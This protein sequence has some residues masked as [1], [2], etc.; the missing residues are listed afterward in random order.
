MNYYMWHGGT[1]FGRW[2]GGPF[3]ITSYDYD[4]MLDEYGLPNQPKYSHLRYVKK[5]RATMRERGR[6]GER[7]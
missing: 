6:E 5:R 2:V 1:N 4:V 3:I 7:E